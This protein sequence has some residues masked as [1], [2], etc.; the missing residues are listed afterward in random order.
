MAITGALYFY[1]ITNY[2]NPA[3]IYKQNL[4]YVHVTLVAQ[5]CSASHL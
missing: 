5:M 3:A 2:A 4:W 1:L